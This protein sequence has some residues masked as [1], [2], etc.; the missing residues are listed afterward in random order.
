MPVYARVHITVSPCYSFYMKTTIL[1]GDRPTGKLHLGHLIGSIEKRLE[2]QQTA[3]EN[4]YL[5]ADMQALTDNA[6]NPD[7]VRSSVL[8]VALDNLA[9]GLDPSKVTMFVQSQVPERSQL[10]MLFLNLVTL[11]RLKRNPTVKAEMQQKGFGEDVP[12]GF[13]MYPVDQ[14]ADILCVRGNTVP[15]GNDQLPMIEQANEIVL[16]FNRLYP[17]DTPV[18]NKV[19]A[20]VSSDETK[21]RLIGLDG[22]AK[23]SKSLSNAIYLA[24]DDATIEQKVLSMYTDPGHIHLNDPGKVEGNVVFTY[25]DIFDP[26]TEAVADLKAHYQKGGLGDV[27]LKRR[28][29]KL[30]QERIAPIRERREHLAKNPEQVLDILREGTA[31]ARE[32]V[33]QT[34]H[35][36]HAALRINYF[37]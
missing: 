20:V 15:V 3:D 24:D 25:L 17:T 27:T 34:V 30:L 7:K 33:K 37:D 9:C 28:L 5:I 18:F 32:I 35:D 26:E 2:L 10:T 13:L 29:I 21:S 6:D 11:A 1:T 19:I 36:V 31:K 14:A 4:F 12:A 8:E 16:A 22:Q 23:M